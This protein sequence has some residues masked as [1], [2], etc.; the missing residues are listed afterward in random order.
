MEVKTLD[1]KGEA[2]AEF[3]RRL[4]AS[5]AGGQIA[6]IVLYGSYARGEAGPESDVDVLILTAGP[7]REIDRIAGEV[8]SDVWLERGDRVEP[9]VHSW[10]EAV[11]V[12]SPFIRRVLR[13]GWEVYRMSDDELKRQEI[14]ALYE[15]A[16]MYLAAARDRYNALSEGSR[17]L[18]A[19]GAYNAIELAA[20]AFLRTKSENLPKTHDGVSNRF[21]D[22]FV[23]TGIVPRIFGGRLSDALRLRN[24]ARYNRNVNIEPEQVQE[25]LNF[26]E[27]MLRALEAFLTSAAGS[28]EAAEPGE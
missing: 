7:V 18:T 23:R 15:L 12:E 20:K 25:T 5:P 1:R 19:D 2:L 4:R 14:K 28:Q 24:R 17:R 26:A 6:Q 21:S 11:V 13:E 9:M 27:E 22:L 8:A 10:A 3:V 16:E